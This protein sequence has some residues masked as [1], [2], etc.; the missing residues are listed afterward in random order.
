MKLES[1][2]TVAILAVA[3]SAAAQGGGGGVGGRARGGAGTS[4]PGVQLP[5]VPVEGRVVP[6]APYSCEAV[7]ESVQVLSDGN[8]IAKKTTARIYRDSDGRTRREQLGADGELESAAI[9]DPVSESAYVLLPKSKTA[10]RNSVVMLAPTAS[11]PVPLPSGSPG[12]VV[13]TRTPEGGAEA[14]AEVR[15]RAMVVERSE[16][17]GRGRGGANVVEFRASSPS[18][19]PAERGETTTEDLG[20]QVI[21]GVAATGTRT[22]TVIPAGSIGNEQPIKIVSEQWFS[23]ELKVLVMTKHSDPRTG[24]T[25]YRLTNISQAEPARSL[26][27]VPADYTL[28]DSLIRRQDPSMQQ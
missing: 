20:Q 16:T 7:T 21:E 19:M 3:T 23:P 8:R 24:E 27:E 25:T 14:G 15:T 6:G 17:A 9:S 18:G 12:V 4:A 1:V 10:F 5:R 13:A 26:F 28:K 11:A 2:V 22:T